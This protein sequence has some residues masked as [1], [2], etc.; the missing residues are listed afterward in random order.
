MHTVHTQLP[1]AM[2]VLALKDG[3]FIAW[4]DDC[5]RSRATARTFGVEII[6]LGRQGGRQPMRYLRLMWRT[7]QLLRARK[8]KTIICLNQPPML[9][10]VCALWA[11]G[12]N[13]DVIQDFHSGALSKPQWR[14]FQPLY[15]WMT[16][17]APVTLMHNRAD[18]GIVA[19]WR[20]ATALLLTL[21]SAAPLG[22]ERQVSGDRPR[23]MFVCT[24]ATD[25]P[26]ELAI[27]AFA[28]CPEADFWITGNYRKA[29]LDQA[30]MPANVRLLGFID[31]ATYQQVMAGSTA[32][33]TLSDRP[34]IMQMAVEEAIS[35]GVP[36][37]TNHS[38]T[39][40]EALG[41]A[42]VFTSLDA[43]ALAAGVRQ[44]LDQQPQLEL[45]ASTARQRC[46]AAVQLELD[47]LRT[48]RPELFC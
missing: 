11:A 42:G 9:P 10:L 15:R 34:H 2:P 31:Y 45:A 22:V 44:V 7:W 32:V 40:A 29:G 30:K 19:A 28:A 1:T 46:W 25:E 41:A 26:V 12:H 36:V 33:I 21:P 13:G 6:F 48:R 17:R 38:P 24:F 39:L 16:R 27:E 18:A 4:K 14:L 8:P 43:A 35:L 20:S 37:L 5:F 3:L 47:G 23:F